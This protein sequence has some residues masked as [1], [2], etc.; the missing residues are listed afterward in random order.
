MTNG[1]KD[2]VDLDLASDESL[3]ELSETYMDEI[4]LN[5]LWIKWASFASEK[6]NQ[7]CLVKIL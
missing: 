2:P 6:G 3:L 5:N 1:G 4:D 7:N